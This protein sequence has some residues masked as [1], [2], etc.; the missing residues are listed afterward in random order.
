MSKG[1]V[2][3]FVLIMHFL[4]N[5]REPYHITIEFFEIINTLE[6]AM[7]LQMN[8]VLAKTQVECLYSCICVKDER[9]NLFIMTFSLTLISFKIL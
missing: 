9:N 5:K 1:N 6:S 7:A 2:N 4:N 8:I 3:T